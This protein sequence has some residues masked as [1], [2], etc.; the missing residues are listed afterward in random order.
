MLKPIQFRQNSTTAITNRGPS[1]SIWDDCPV[2]AILNDPGLGIY[3]FQDFISGGLITSPTTEAALVGYPVSG[4]SSDATQVAYGNA[5]FTTT[6][7]DAGT[8]ALANTTN[9]HATNIRSA[10]TPYRISQTFGDFFF[11]CRFKTALIATTENSFFVGVM[12]D[13]AGTVAVPL[14]T[15]GELAD[16][17]LVGFHKPEANTTTFN[18]SYKADGITAVAVNSGIGTLVADTYVKVGMRFKSAD[19]KLYYYV[20]GVEQTTKKSIPDNTGTDFPADKA[21]GWIIA[22]A[23][24]AGASDNILTADW[25][26]C[27]QLFKL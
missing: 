11:E 2:L 25:I 20:D 24:G 6:V 17:N 9:D 5:T 21:L 18:G 27:A 19:K 23:V 1:P 8:F 15:T 26:R 10:I 3:D 22:M 13:T 7:N 12:E 14:L 4:F 16:K